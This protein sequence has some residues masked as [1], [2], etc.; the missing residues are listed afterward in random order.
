MI[1]SGKMSR[2]GGKGN[3][4]GVRGLQSIPTADR[5]SSRQPDGLP[6]KKARSHSSAATRVLTSRVADAMIR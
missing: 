5:H 4:G 3:F 2:R 6:V 1:K